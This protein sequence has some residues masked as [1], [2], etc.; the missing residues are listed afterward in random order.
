MLTNS[1]TL[2]LVLGLVT[3]VACGGEQEEV[4]PPPTLAPSVP[5]E[6]PAPTAEAPPPPPAKPPLADLEKT[7]LAAAGAALNA[8]DAVKLAGLY[9]DDAVIRVAGLNEVTGRDAIM[10]NMQEWFDTF[11][12]VKVGFGRVWFAGDVVVLEW[13]LNGTYTGDFFGVKGKDQPIGHL[14]LS[15]LWFNPDGR[16]KEEHRYGDLG[17]VMQQVTKTAAPPL[18]T[19]PDAPQMFAPSGSAEETARLDLVK[20][21]YGAIEKKGE[22]DFLALLADDVE[23]EGH[24]GKVKGRAEAKKFFQ[25]LTK[26]FPDAAFTVSNAWAVGD[27][28]IVEY[29]LNGTNKGTLLGLAPTN[30]PVSV[31]AVDVVRVE[32]GKIARAATYSNGLELMTQLGAFKVGAPVVPPS[33][34]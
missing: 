24:L 6:T 7:A 10:K 32:G 21:L 18:P 20:K 11:S 3:L 14:G 13:V 1:R 8:H 34:K 29:T 16:V 31:H 15:V 33:K 28:V 25:S 5:F 2:A 22:S 23:Y 19:I 4:K 30:R 9:A 26:G 17:A 27:Y 12:N